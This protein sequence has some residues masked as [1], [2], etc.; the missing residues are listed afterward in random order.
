MKVSEMIK[1]LQEFMKENGDLECW[2]ARD[3][4]GNGY[5]EVSYKPSLYYIDS[6]G[7]ILHDEEDLAYYDLTLEDVEKICIVN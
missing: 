1:N 6:M 5:Q 3:D 4:E 7:D 2:Y